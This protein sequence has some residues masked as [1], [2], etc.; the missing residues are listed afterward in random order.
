[1]RS[2][3]MPRVLR[4]G[5]RAAG[6]VARLQGVT[7]DE[8]KFQLG[9]LPLQRGGRIPDAHLGYRT[10]GQLNADKSN[11]ILYPT[12]FTGY[13]DNNEWLV[14]KGMALDPEK[15]F[16]IVVSAMGNGVSSSPSN[17]PE[18]YNAWRFPNVTLFDNVSSQHRFVTEKFGIKK[19]QLVTGWSM[20]AQQTFGW[21]SQYPEMVPRA[22]PFCGSSKTAPHNFVFLEGVKAALTADAAW[23]HGRYQSP[24]KQGLRSVGRVYAGWGLSQP[25]YREERWRGLGFNSL[26]DF[27][28]GFWEGFFLQRDA[29]NLLA[30]L[31]TWQHADISANDK[32]NGDLVKALNAIKA[33]TKVLAPNID[34]YFPKEDNQ[35][36]VQHIPK[37]EYIEIPGVFGHFAGGGLCD[38]DTNFLDKHLKELLS[39]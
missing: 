24:P 17:T 7:I 22:A 8:G 6:G 4:A 26:E 35:W 38:T 14:G 28:V 11:A 13:H 32:F 19:F 34:L 37:G 25:F 15:Y 27:L 1:M 20:G 5:A 10:Y 3:C 21:A 18:P 12:W 33:D 39:R 30:M 9:D 2:W 29:N 36:E 23:D 31:W 16:I